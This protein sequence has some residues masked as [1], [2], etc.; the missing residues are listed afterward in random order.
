M[1]V[2]AGNDADNSRS[3][4]TDLHGSDGND[5]FPETRIN[6]DILKNKHKS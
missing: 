6:T 4:D 1:M 2:F 5:F 3:L